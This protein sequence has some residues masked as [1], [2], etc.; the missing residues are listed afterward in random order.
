MTTLG[1]NNLSIGDVVRRSKPDG[2][3]A[4]I[5]EMLDQINGLA[6]DAPWV[7]GDLP[8]G[9]YS[10]QRTSL[11]SFSTRNPN[12]ASSIAKSTTSQTL[13]PMEYIESFSE[14]DELVARYGGDVSAKQASEA[15]AFAQG[16]IQTISSRILS[17][18]GSTTPGQINGIETR[19][20]STTA[21]NGRNVILGGAAGG[22]T[23]CMSIIFC[24][25]GEGKVYGLYPRG[26]KAGLEVKN[27]G[28]LITEV[29]ATTRA[30]KY[31]EQWLWGFGLA[32]D[33]WRSVVRIANID[34]SLLVAG[35]GADLFDK[36]TQ[37]WHCLERSVGMGRPAA[38]LNTTT[39]MMLDIQARNDVI[40]GGGLKFENVGGQMVETFRGIPLNIED[41]LTEAESVVS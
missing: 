8:G 36:M 29:S 16:A 10:T 33:D 5:V 19:Y 30:V 15:H 21:D 31:T 1:T 39:R 11:P 41:K 38:Y 37:A 7:E 2:S 28:P 17:G 35:T 32:V 3:L 9:H 24:K 22:Q 26:S 12:G 20:S 18:N 14:V 25:W 6:K 13:E 4:V 27:W 34:K 23:D 40:S